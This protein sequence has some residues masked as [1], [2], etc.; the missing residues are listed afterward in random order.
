MK[1]T[2]NTDPNYTSQLGHKVQFWVG[3]VVGYEHQTEQLSN[4]NDWRYKV[5]II[6]DHSDVDQVDD[7][8]LSYASVL[9]STD[10]GSGAAY[11]LRSA[12]ISQGDTVYGIRGPYIPTLIIGVEPRK[13]STILHSGGKFKTLSG[14]YESLTNNNILSGEFNEQL[15]PATPGGAPY[16]KTK[17][18]REPATEKLNELGID[19]EEEGVVEDVNE[20]ITPKKDD[21][22]KPWTVGDHLSTDKLFDIQEKVKNGE[23]N[24][25]LLLAAA[26]QGE[27]QGIIEKAT[28]KKLVSD[29]NI[30]IANNTSSSYTIA[31]VEYDTATGLPYTYVDGAGNKYTS[32][33]LEELNRSSG[34]TVDPGGT[35]REDGTYVPPGFEDFVPID[36][37]L[38][39]PN[40]GTFRNGTYFPPGFED[41]TTID[42]DNTA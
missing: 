33:D 41:A 28:S 22:T 20:K 30:L 7:K 40:E 34:N 13:R 9:L 15:G 31:G 21:V 39:E 6:G 1:H 4:G 8:D 32:K 12:R 17:T 36:Q 37:I 26:K 19:P 38:G 42:Y 2:P 27:E 23:E 5:R 14:F 11:K 24:P 16:T 35:F 29:A 3:V 25:R 18:E 10:A